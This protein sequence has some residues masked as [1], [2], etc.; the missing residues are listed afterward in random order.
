MY[1]DIITL[2]I[3]NRRSIKESKLSDS[4]ISTISIV[5]EL[6]IIDSKKAFFILL[7]REYIKLF[8]KLWDRTKFNRTKGN[9]NYVINKIIEYISV[10]I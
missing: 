8:L 1:N 10:Y 2:N 6:L 9:L 5:G 7:S 4:E 3:I